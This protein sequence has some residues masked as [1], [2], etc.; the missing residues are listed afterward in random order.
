MPVSN[1]TLAPGTVLVS[2]YRGRTVRCEVVETPDG[3]RYRFEG[4]DYKSPSSAGRA[5]TGRVSCDGWTFWSLEGGEQPAA[6]PEPQPAKP[7][8]TKAKPAPAAAPKRF[9]QIKP[10]R[11][12]DGCQEGERRWFCSACMAGFCLPKG[13]TPETCPEGHPREV[14]DELASP[15][16]DAEKAEA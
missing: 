10:T 4:K 8:A 15:E 11:K 6:T 7:K 5:V 2:K 1:R 16:G 3:V 9:V 12:Q 14:E 13:Q